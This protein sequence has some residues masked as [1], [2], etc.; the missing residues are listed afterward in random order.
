[1]D[2]KGID[3]K[4]NE[5][6]NIKQNNKKEKK[7]STPNNFKGVKKSIVEKDDS[8][9]IKFPIIIS[10]NKTLLKLGEIEYK[11]EKFHTATHIF[12]VG[13]KVST[14]SKSIGIHISCLSL[15]FFFLCVV[16]GFEEKKH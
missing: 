5:T 13:Y 2:N 3:N 14:K 8:G 6:P 7:I 15:Y 11:D 9:N 12:P 10:A 4:E 16:L 1:M